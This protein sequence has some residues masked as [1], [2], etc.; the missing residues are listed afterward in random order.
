[1]ERTTRIMCQFCQGGGVVWAP[2]M[3]CQWGSAETF[4]L[5]APVTCP[6]CQGASWFELVEEPVTPPGESA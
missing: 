5:A 6:E 3:A 4:S 1:M 2:K